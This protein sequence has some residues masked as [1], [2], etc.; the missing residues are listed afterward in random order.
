MSENTKNTPTKNLSEDITIGQAMSRDLMPQI[1][2]TKS[3][4]QKL[5]SKGVNH[6]V[7][8]LDTADLK[9]SQS[10]FDRDK[11][12]SMVGQKNEPSIVSRDGH[13]LDGHHRAMADDLSKGKTKVIK[14]DMNILD[15]ISTAKRSSLDE[16]VTHKEFG[17][18]L[19]S[20][21]SFA[22]DY[23]G[24]DS[25]PKIRYKESG[26]S[27]ASFGGYNPGTQ[28]IVIQTKGRHPM[29]VLRTLA[30]ELVHH[31]QKE[32]GE[33]TLKNA[34]ESGKTGSKI[35]RHAN[36]EAGDMMRHFRKGN[37]KLFDSGPL[38]EAFLAEAA[39]R[40]KD[41]V[42][43]KT[44][45][46]GGGAGSGKDYVLKKVLSGHGLKE[47]NSDHAFKYLLK[48]EG[49]PE[50]VPQSPRRDKIRNKALS[51]TQV[52]QNALLAG[53]RGI[54][55]NTTA[56][57]P[58]KITQLKTE[59]ERQ[60][61]DVKMLFVHT[62][63]EVSRAR[64][65]ARGKA[66]GRAV[67]EEIRSVN[68][69]N[70]QK[71]KK[72]YK[73]LFGDHYHE[74][75]NSL[76]MNTASDEQK[77]AKE[78][79]FTSLYKKIGGW[80]ASK[81]D[82]PVGRAQ[83]ETELSKRRNRSKKTVKKPATTAA[84]PKRTIFNVV[85]PEVNAAAK[86]LGLAHRGNNYWGPRKKGPGNTPIITHRVNE[87]G[88]LVKVSPKKTPL[89]PQPIKEDLRDW[90][91]PKHP[92]GGWKRI[93]SKGEA[94]GPCA[95][96]KGE[97]KPKCMSNEKRAKLTKKERAAAVKAKR[98][99]DPNPERKGNPINV[100][101]FGKGR[102]EE[103]NKPTNPELWARAKSLA[104]KKFD[105]Y[106][107]VPMDSQA[108]T[109]EG[110]K[111]YEE[112]SIG[113]EILTYNITKDVLEWKPITHLHFYESAPLK[114]IYK[115]TGFSIRATKNHKWV[116]RTGES[117]DK[118]SLVETKDIHKRMRIITCATLENN[119]GTLL[120]ESWSKKDNWVSKIL[121]WPKTM[122]EVF[123]ASSIVY[124]GHDVGGS[125]KIKD[126]HTFG[127]SQKN[128]DHFWAALLAAYLNG[129]HVSFHEKT[130]S[131]SGASIIRNKKYHGTQNLI[132]E[133]DN[134]E[135][136]WC[137]TTDNETWV[138]VQNGFI[139]ITG[140]SAYANGWAS[141]W[142]KSKGGGWKS[143]NETFDDY[144]SNSANRLLGSDSLVKIYKKMTP[145]Q[146][147]NDTM[148]KNTIETHP[149]VPE[150]TQKKKKKG[151]K[152]KKLTQEA[153]VTASASD[154]VL[155]SPTGVGPP[156]GGGIGPEF[157]IGRSGMLGIAGTPYGTGMPAN[158][159][160]F[161][162]YGLVESVETWAKNPKTIAAYRTRY[163]ARADQKLKEDKDKM[164][165]KTLTQLR[166]AWGDRYGA[167]GTVPA[168]NTNKDEGIAEDS[169]AWQ[170]KEGKRES[171]GLNQ[172]G[173]KSYRRE[174]PG[175]KLQT[176]V[177]TKPSKLK[178][179]SKA[180]KRRLSFCRR[181]KGM[182]AKLTS[183]KTARDPDSRINKSLRAWNCEE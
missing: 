27:F 50:T 38:V 21:V 174:N 12:K 164:S 145:D 178:K 59:L 137:P 149:L 49:L 172:K 126:R 96:E 46:L 83:L 18:M 151:W 122:R 47:V 95:R 123:L 73:K 140:N 35:E 103:E 55:I 9:T 170:R 31:K 163:G 157:G 93:N 48:K 65:E 28:E 40:P 81:P 75:D 10:E 15:L 37:E 143:V 120:E 107:C 79:E 100:S 32:N 69:K 104:K 177:T 156:S 20:F 150:E 101:N 154:S 66:G 102:L 76:D 181:M 146:Y 152:R 54:V 57:E 117:Y 17:P 14:V 51:L 63:N 115:S 176:A 22:S 74:V 44:V 114:K 19:D 141:K 80:A 132:I 39:V 142:Y 135:D 166:E 86:S 78:A 130:E 118:V 125:T 110:L 139:T 6:K 180:A 98:K 167:M 67:P 34:E 26:E 90:F 133:D 182:K 91:N 175:S 71:A 13:I 105:V 109:K 127:F 5:R 158:F 111:T 45:I 64:N 121:S 124:D 42:R 99:H 7:E 61:H 88:A 159:S 116:V 106:P 169:P 134:I 41:D 129:Y 2:D 138:M 89:I 108:I 77:G 136:V 82:N 16:E 68:W 1:T 52:R 179:G 87:K 8:T 161:G 85:S 128:N 72:H 24:I 113:E 62:S 165:G 97:P 25:L 153:G 58:E 36:A 171:G 84:K 23:L 94:I 112:L 131:I 4:L 119:D 160:S 53:K 30:H 183:A 33:I 168:T 147:A 11:I 173:V 92:E 155:V 43:F 56:S 29:D 148:I 144:M 3:F 60:G 162:T 70:A